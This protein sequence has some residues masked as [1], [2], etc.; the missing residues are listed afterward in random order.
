MKPTFI[1]REVYILWRFINNDIWDTILP[2]MIIF[3][4]AWKFSDRPWREIPIPLFVAITYACLYIYTF[5]ISN[6]IAGIEEDRLNKPYRPLPTGLVTIEE[7]RIRLVVYS[8]FY[9]LVAYFLQ[10]FWYSLAWVV[11]SLC[12]NLYGWSNH[13]V[14]KNLLGMSLGTF[15]LFN[16]QWKIAQPFQ[17]IGTNT[18]IYFTFMSLWAGFALPLQDMR[19][20][21][22]DRLLGRKTLPLAI[23][24]KG[25]RIALF[26]NFLTLSPLLLLCAMLTQVTI[27][28]LVTDTLAIVIFLTQILIHWGIAIRIMLYKNP[29]ADHKTYLW[30]VFLFCAGIPIICFI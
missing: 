8:L 6:Q 1:W 7:T 2:S 12:L 29:T 26:L 19:D 5:C 10:I 23:G 24:D 9:L 21:E 16:V 22:G 11:V 20:Q 30:Y 27:L 4:T 14:S 17:V 15:I 18:E 28:E 3:F 25:A 13:W